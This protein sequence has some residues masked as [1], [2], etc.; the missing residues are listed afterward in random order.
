MP[1]IPY[2]YP[3]SLR[4]TCKILMHVQAPNNS[5]NCLC[6]GSLATAP[7]LPYV[8]AGTQHFTPKS[9]HLCRFLTIQKIAYARAGFQQFTR[10]SL[11]L[12]RFPMLH[13][14]NPDG[15][16][17]CQHFRPFLRPGKPPKNSKNFLH[18]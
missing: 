10:K 12:Y 5:N 14:Q 7:T 9:L 6:Q 8:G 16:T 11:R 1:T 15:C 13:T 2:A 17:G 3:G 4:F 18:D